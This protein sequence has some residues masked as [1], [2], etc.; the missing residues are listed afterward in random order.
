MIVNLY[1][2]WQETP[3]INKENS[4]EIWQIPFPAVT[5]CPETKVNSKFLK[6]INGNKKYELSLD[7]RIKLEALTQLCDPDY[8]DG[9]K[10][11]IE[12][13]QIVPTLQGI[14]PKIENTFKDCEWERNWEY[15]NQLF[16][17]IMTEEGSCFTFNMLNSSEIFRK[18]V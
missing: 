18:G 1:T 4:T 12:L 2:A 11:Q 17:Q 9:N 13:N 6:F 3:F 7:N 16:S 10:S 15:C 5:I 8:F 14:A